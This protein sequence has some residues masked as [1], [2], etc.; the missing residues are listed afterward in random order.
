LALK[1]ERNNELIVSLSGSFI[2]TEGTRG[3]VFVL[4]DLTEARKLEEKIRQTE[5]LASI[6]SMVSQLAHEIKNPLSSIRTFTELLPEKFEDEEFRDRFFSLVSGEVKRID[7][8]VSR[9]LNLGQVQPGRFREISPQKTIDNVLRSLELRLRDQNIE[10]EVSCEANI[11][12]IWADPRR[13]EEAFSNVLVNSIEA[14]PKG[15]K[16][17]V[18]LRSRKDKNGNKNGLE[19]VITDEGGGI[20]K[21]N[22]PRIFEPFFTTKQQGSGLGLYI[23]YQII[24]SHGGEIEVRN[25]GKGAH[26][27]IFLPITKERAFFIDGKREI[28]DKHTLHY[29]R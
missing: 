28:H 17:K 22:L 13:L 19:V 15:G 26:V 21:K 25:A 27:R 4:T 20:S 6:G 23:C 16:V 1:T 24:R 14:M 12:P 3:V 29:P 10:T 2:D 5:K 9:M 11:L 8:L 18:F 7:G